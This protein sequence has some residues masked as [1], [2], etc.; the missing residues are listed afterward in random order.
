V[1]HIPFRDGSFD[2]AVA[3]QVLEHLPFSWFR[4]AL[5]ELGRVARRR[6]LISL[7]D[8]RYYLRILI[9]PFSLRFQLRWMVSFPRVRYRRMTSQGFTLG[10]GH[11][12]EIGRRGYPLRRVKE[13]VPSN[14]RLVRAYRLWHN[15]Y[16]HM[17]VLEKVG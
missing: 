14:L 16:H 5:A 8:N 15:P 3:F 1:S 7:P 13:Q 12:W 11:L 4:P 6:V 10:G 17:F 9:N 2:M